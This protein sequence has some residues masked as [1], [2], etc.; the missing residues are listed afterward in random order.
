M[1]SP[2]AIPPAAMSGRHVARRTCGMSVIV[3]VSSRPLCPP[4]SKPSATTASTPASSHLRANLLLDTTW[5]TVIPASWSIAVNFFGLPAEVNTIFTPLSMM[6]FIR[7]SI[8]GYISGTFTPQGLSVA[9]FIL[10][11]CSSS[12]SGCIEPAPS[13]PSPP[14]LLTAEASLQPLHHTIPP[15]TTGYFIPNSSVILFFSIIFQFG[16]KRY[17]I[18][19]YTPKHAYVK[20]KTGKSCDANAA[21]S[22]VPR[23][24]LI[25]SMLPVALQKAV[26]QLAKDGLL[27]CD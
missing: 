4:A 5:A 15:C 25:V 6:S 13:R 3:V 12:V 24:F 1:A 22:G 19:K 20:I 18:C 14:A 7:R 8:S 17:S 10:A 21:D 2:D 26:F 9:S 11:M 23:N 16:L 27:E